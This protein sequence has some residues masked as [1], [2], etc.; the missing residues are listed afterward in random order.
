M[1][2]NIDVMADTILA[3]KRIKDLQEDNEELKKSLLRSRV[4]FVTITALTVVVFIARFM[5]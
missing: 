2:E 4:Y 1:H 3:E 5:I